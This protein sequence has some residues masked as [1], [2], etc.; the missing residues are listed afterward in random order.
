MLRK[1]IQLIAD[2]T[3]LDALKSY[4]TLP[5]VAKGRDLAANFGQDFLEY[6][7]RTGEED[8]ATAVQ[9]E[10]DKNEFLDW[11]F[12]EALPDPAFEG[13]YRNLPQGIL[14]D[15]QSPTY[16]FMDFERDVDNEW[17]IHGTND[18]G[19]IEANGFTRGVWDFAT[20]GLTT[21]FVD[22]VKTGGFNFAFYAASFHERDVLA[23]GKEAVV[24]RASGIEVYHHGD[25]QRQII[26]LGDTATDIHSITYYSGSYYVRIN[27]VE[28]EGG[29]EDVEVEGSLKECTDWIMEHV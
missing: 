11:P 16:L 29:L 25:Q 22:K 27:D 5:P 18:A 17:L 1:A 24:F 9:A 4:L 28:V 26:F 14:E 23:Y 19:S 8:L 13:F 2:L 12:L 6:L 7:L 10:I 15:P 21:H 20:L 3:D